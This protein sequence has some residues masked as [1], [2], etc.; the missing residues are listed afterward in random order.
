MQ[1]RLEMHI[2]NVPD[3]T[4]RKH[5]RGDTI[6][7][8]DLSLKYIGFTSGE[9]QRVSVGRHDSSIGFGAP[10]RANMRSGAPASAVVASSL[11][12]SVD[13]DDLIAYGLI[14]EFVGRFPIL[15]TLSAL[16]EKQLVQVLME[17]KNAL[18]KQYRKMFN[19]NNVKLHMT[20]GALRLIAQKS[21]SK[22]TG[23]RGLRSIMERILTEA[24]FE[25]PDLKTGRDR[26]DA[27]LIDEEAVGSVD[28]MGVGAKILRGEGALESFLCGTKSTHDKV[29]I[30][31]EKVSVDRES[32]MKRRA[33]SL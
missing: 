32:E 5:S 4:S 1:G 26:V 23:A 17:P 18:S 21:M 19:M 11:L 9:R 7:E 33:M 10:V 6:Q 22:N 3:K 24:M 25:V 8:H 14:P 27:V 2:V 15:V 30:A 12:E 20:E 16:N 13:S 31:T 29:E 28:T